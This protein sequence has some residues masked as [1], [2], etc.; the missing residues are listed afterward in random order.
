[1]P[2]LQCAADSLQIE[3]LL[4]HDA[5]VAVL[6]QVTGPEFPEE[7]GRAE[8]LLSQQVAVIPKNIRQ[9]HIGDETWETEKDRP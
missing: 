8:N 6:R 4:L 9:T 2:D 3:R 7:G 1:M 5:G